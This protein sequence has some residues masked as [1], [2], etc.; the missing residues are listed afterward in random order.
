[1]NSDFTRQVIFLSQQ[2]DCS[3]RYVAGLLHNAMSENP[4]I[5]PVQCLEIT[6]AEYHQRRR[7]LVDCLLYLME[8]TEASEAPDLPPTYARIANFVRVELLGAPAAEAFALK[9]F[10]QVEALD[11]VIG[12]ADLARKSASSNTTLPSGQGQFSC[13]SSIV[14]M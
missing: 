3:E 6:I 14:F 8:A 5:S 4:N 2:L 7:H 10:K 1:M 13:S 12:K 11:V 9:I